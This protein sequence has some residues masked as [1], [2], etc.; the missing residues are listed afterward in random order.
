MEY[1]S[2]NLQKCKDTAMK[3]GQSLTY[4]DRDKDTGTCFPSNNANMAIFGVNS[5]V[6]PQPDSNWSCSSSGEGCFPTPGLAGDCTFKVNNP[7]NVSEN[8]QNVCCKPQPYMSLNS[9]WGPQ[10]KY[11]L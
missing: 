6:N 9:T 5:C 3:N 1:N 11:T 4:W 10:K 2:T 8:Y 7:G